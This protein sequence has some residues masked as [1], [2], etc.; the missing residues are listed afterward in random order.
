M[1]ITNASV[2][3]SGSTLTL[4]FTY[5]PGDRVVMVDEPASLVVNYTAKV[6]SPTP[7]PLAAA[8]PGRTWTLASDD[9]TAHKATFT[10]VV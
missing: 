10:A 9:T 7:A 3:Q 4:T 6:A 1:A 8:D 5:D 2:T